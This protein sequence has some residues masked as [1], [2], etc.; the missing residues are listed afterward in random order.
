MSKSGWERWGPIAGIAF[1]VLFVVG[2]SLI[3]TP[4]S[5]EPLAK[6]KEFYDDAGNRAQVIISAYLLILSGIFFLWF[7]ASL[8]V[9]LLSAEH[10]PGRLTSIAFAGGIVFVSMLIA[11]ASVGAFI[12]GEISFGDVENINPE[13][14][15]VIPDLQYPLLL[16]GGMFGAIAMIDAASVLIVRTGTLPRWIGWFGF[17]AAVGLLFAGFFLPIILLLLWVLFVSIALLRLDP[18]GVPD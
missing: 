6:F 18:A 7:L 5:D 9:R 12:A 14:M 3:N 11:A 2:V 1:V 4:E 10:P 16:I 17:V 13:L 15:R 8:R